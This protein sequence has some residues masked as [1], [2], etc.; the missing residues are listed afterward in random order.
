[1]STST[2]AKRDDGGVTAGVAIDYA[3]VLRTLRLNPADPKTQALVLVCERYGLDPVLKHVVLVDGNVYVTRDG[4]LHVAHKSGKLDGIEVVDEPKL[5][6]DKQHWTA[7]VAVYRRDMSRPFSYVGRYPAKG[8]N[9]KYAPEMAVKCAEVM[10]LRRAFDVAIAARE[11]LHDAVETP[12]QQLAPAQPVSEQPRTE[13]AP[14]NGA[15]SAHGPLD[16]IR[17]AA[18]DATS[19]DV[20]RDLY[21]ESH[22]AGLLDAQTALD[23]GETCTLAELIMVERQRVLDGLP[24]HGP[25]ADEP[26]GEPEQQPVETPEQTQPVVEPTPTEQLR[27]HVAAAKRESS[28]RARKSDATPVEPTVERVVEQLGG[29]VVEHDGWPTVAQPPSGGDA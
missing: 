9:Q 23:D 1:M 20:L 18:F 26:L 27:E 2:I 24:P 15:Q 4:L 6:D 21:R 11:E 19:E 8:G 17:A 22:R 25:D 7:K 10:A 5:T 14:E 12:L 28:K 16:A 3:A 13:N 29:T